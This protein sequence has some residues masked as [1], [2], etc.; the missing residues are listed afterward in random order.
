MKNILSIAALAAIVGA[1]GSAQAN[2]VQNPSFETTTTGFYY[3]VGNN[4]YWYNLGTYDGGTLRGVSPTQVDLFPSPQDTPS[5]WT[6]QPPGNFMYMDG[7]MTPTANYQTYAF[8]QT[9]SGLTPGQTYVLTFLAAYAPEYPAPG[10]TI[11]WEANLG[12][13]AN[14]ALNGGADFSGFTGGDTVNGPVVDIP[15]NGLGWVPVTLDLTATA[16]TETLTFIALGTGAP[17]FALITNINMT[18]VPEPST[19]AMMGIGFAGLGGLTVLA[20]RRRAA[21]AAAVA[22]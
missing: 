10:D 3:G 19:W 18:A 15:A 13:T 17:P 4:K 20:R 2:L 14:F 12:G 6:A 7:G 9:I 1:S 8:G 5:N 22:S 11:M 16:S 21:A